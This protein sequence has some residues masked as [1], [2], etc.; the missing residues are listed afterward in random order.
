MCLFWII[1]FFFRI[2][3]FLDLFMSYKHWNSVIFKAQGKFHFICVIFC[4]QT[5]TITYKLFI[6]HA[7]QR[8]SAVLTDKRQT[9]F[10]YEDICVYMYIYIFI[11]IYNGGKQIFFVF[12]TQPPKLSGIVSKE[13]NKR[14]VAKVICSAQNLKSCLP[15]CLKSLER[16]VTYVLRVIFYF[17]IFFSFVLGLNS[18]DD[19]V[20]GTLCSRAW[21]REVRVEVG[22]RGIHIF[23]VLFS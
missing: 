18:P 4:F 6:T 7:L 9:V 19:Y 17:I 12:P 11:F 5:L 13:C 10:L 20:P 22:S 3:K 15:V 23:F 8:L 2:L 21:Q 16:H 1:R 14:V